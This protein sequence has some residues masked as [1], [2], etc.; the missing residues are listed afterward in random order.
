MILHW[1]QIANHYGYG[2]IEIKGGKHRGKWAAQDYF[3]HYQKKYL[4]AARATYGFLFSPVSFEELER[5]QSGDGKHAEEN[6]LETDTWKRDIPVAIDNSFQGYTDTFNVI[7]GINR[8][9]CGKCTKLLIEKLDAI[10]RRFP[11]RAEKARFI[12]ACLGAYKPGETKPEEPRTSV[13]D[14][15]LLIRAGWEPCVLQ[16]SKSLTQNGAVLKE[17]LEHLGRRGIMR[18]ESR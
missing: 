17:T 1:D 6:L 18:L 9:P 2:E 5:A 13:R 15:T 3:K 10:Y 14:L 4:R 11:L 7:L 16:T 8:T 12:L